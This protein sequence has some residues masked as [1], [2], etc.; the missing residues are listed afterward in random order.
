MNN[1]LFIA[2][3]FPPHGGGGVQRTTKFVKYLARYGWQPTVLSA[4]DVGLRD[5]SLVSDV[6]PDLRVERTR[7]LLLPSWMPYRVQKWIA[8]WF[9]ITDMELGWLPFAVQKGKHLL[10]EQPFNAL[11]STS[12]PHTSH[13]VGLW[14]SQRYKLP[15]VA[16]FRDAWIDHIQFEYPSPLQRLCLHNMVLTTRTTAP[17]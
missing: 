13:I 14:L 15:W 8:R 4:R 16:D 10:H 9:F 7:V 1:V 17:G 5:R 6:P 12:V 11:Y 3:L 2:Y